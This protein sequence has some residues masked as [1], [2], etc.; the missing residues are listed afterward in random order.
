[1]GRH[2]H[3]AVWSPVNGPELE[4]QRRRGEQGDSVC[5]PQQNITDR[6]NPRSKSAATLIRR[7]VFAVISHLFE[8]ERSPS[9]Q[10]LQKGDE[11]RHNVQNKELHYYHINLFSVMMK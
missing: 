8:V 3:R 11:S 10:R 7:K 4:F 9:C 2:C 6:R 1:M 5:S